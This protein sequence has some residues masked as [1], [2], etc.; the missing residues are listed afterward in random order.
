MGCLHYFELWE[1]SCQKKFEL[2]PRRELVIT[3]GEI[4]QVLI[5]LEMMGQDSPRV[6]SE[7]EIM[8]LG[9]GVRLRR[10][11]FTL[12]SLSTTQ[13]CTAVITTC[14]WHQHIHIHIHCFSIKH[15]FITVTV[16]GHFF[17]PSVRGSGRHRSV[18][19][20]LCVIH[21][22]QRHADYDY[23]KKFH[24]WLYIYSCMNDIFLISLSWHLQKLVRVNLH[25]VQTSVISLRV[26][27]FF[28][29]HFLQDLR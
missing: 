14:D 10:R 7:V 5:W 12:W 11:S 13:W 19:I 28:F 25:T 27:T 9:V 29:N 20:C 6:W 26:K 18:V 22:K 24:V 4:H 2:Q 17:L 8:D 1:P 21:I 15:N 23:F 3:K 16:T